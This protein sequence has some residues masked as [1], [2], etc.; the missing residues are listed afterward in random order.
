MENLTQYVTDH[1]WLVAMA[2]V[3]ALLV[4]VYEI[5]MRR[6]AFAAVSPQDLIRLQNQGGIVLDLLTANE[7]LRKHKEKPVVVYCESG[8]TG[9]S[10][11]R[12]LAGQGFKQAY[13]LR[14]GIAAWRTDN[15]PLVQG[16][17]P[18]TGKTKR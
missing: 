9:A 2:V 11:A 13:N 5:R 10:A 1:P 6:D 3:A 12:V 14:G 7:T 16:V 8:S 15:L 17:E 4:L 18:A